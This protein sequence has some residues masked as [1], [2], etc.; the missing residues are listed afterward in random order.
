ME[1]KKPKIS[2]VIPCFEQAQYLSECIESVLAQ[3]YKPH[4]I[5]V[6]NDGS[7]DETRYVAMQYP[8]RYIEQV[9]KGLASARNTGI[10]N[11]TGDYIFP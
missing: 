6:I 4:E 5:I 8:V 11:A 3:T 1:E 10:M 7:Q 2:V 9:N